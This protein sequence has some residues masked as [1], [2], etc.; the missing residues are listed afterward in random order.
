MQILWGE[1]IERISNG[2]EERVR[3]VTVSVTLSVTLEYTAGE[4]E[5]KAVGEL[6]A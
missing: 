5:S 3:I 1:V 4:V 6:K 2:L